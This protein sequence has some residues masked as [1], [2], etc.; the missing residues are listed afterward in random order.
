MQS[1]ANI[2]LYHPW[3]DGE[4]KMR[5]KKGAEVHCH[6]RKPMA[7]CVG[8]DLECVL[9]VARVRWPELGD[10]GKWHSTTVAPVM[11]K[12]SKGEDTSFQ[13]GRYPEGVYDHLWKVFLG[14]KHGSYGVK[15]FNVAYDK[16][17][18]RVKDLSKVDWAKVLGI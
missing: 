13:L 1:R 14:W 12:L 5:W 16:E 18:S 4:G 15:C 3:R 11:V 8:I 2:E 9:S 6:C 17:K 7:E 10:V